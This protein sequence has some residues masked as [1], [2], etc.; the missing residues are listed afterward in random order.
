MLTLLLVG[1]LWQRPF[2][3]RCIVDVES[4]A[5]LNPSQENDVYFLAIHTLLLVG[6]LW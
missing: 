4:L 3:N 6:V 2:V 5:N 1:V